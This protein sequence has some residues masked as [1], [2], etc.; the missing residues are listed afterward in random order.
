MSSVGF[1]FTG[2]SESSVVDVDATLEA[3]ATFAVIDG[4]FGLSIEL[5]DL[6]AFG[7]DA[8]AL[9]GVGASGLQIQSGTSLNARVELS[10]TAFTVDGVEYNF[11]D[12]WAGDRTVHFGGT[13]T[14]NISGVGAE[15]SLTGEI[16]PGLTATLNVTTD[17]PIVVGDHTTVSGNPGAQTHTMTY[18][19]DRIPPTR[20]TCSGTE[21]RC[22]VPA[23]TGSPTARERTMWS[24]TPSRRSRTAWMSPSVRGAS[25]NRGRTTSRSISPLSKARV[26][27][28]WFPTSRSAARDG[29]SKS[30]TTARLCVSTT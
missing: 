24:S 7:D 17:R 8:T 2:S 15:Y 14:L 13:G 10:E 30:A 3:S 6:V 1:D 26:S 20:P 12:D 25:P 9:R 28:R 11:H 21:N 16:L 19:F 22:S 27:T 5:V 29:R 18:I 4:S 23:P